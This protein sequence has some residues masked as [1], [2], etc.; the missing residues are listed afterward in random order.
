MFKI[1]NCFTLLEKFQVKKYLNLPIDLE[2][3]ETGGRGT[4]VDVNRLPFNNSSPPLFVSLERGSTM[5]S[6][7]GGS[8]VGGGKGSGGK[9]R[10]KISP[11]PPPLGSEGEGEVGLTSTS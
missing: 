2:V 4:N 1:P 5:V 11:P 10:G 6:G 7:G 8:V 9:V 3:D